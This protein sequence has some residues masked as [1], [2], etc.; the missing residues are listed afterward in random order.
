[1]I[2]S[3][4]LCLASLFLIAGIV[5]AQTETPAK[6]WTSSVGAG[7]AITSGNT[8]TQNYNVSFSTRYDPKRKFVFKSEAL[9]LRGVSNGETQVDRA[10]ASA[11]GEYTYSDRTFAFV[12]VSYLRD[13]FKAI[14]SLVAPVAGGGYRFLRSDVR[15]LTADIAA[16]AQLQDDTV[17]GRTSS[18]SV[19]MGEDFDW[20]LSPTS[21]LTQKFTALWKAEDFDDALYHFDAGLATSVMTRLELKVAYTYDYKNKPPS[22]TVKKGDS[23]LVAALVFKF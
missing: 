12:E 2:R 23:A 10:A 13:P 7:L 5:Q 1:M 15:N 3:R 18:G 9:W 8:D 4:S 20:A 6:P 16:G 17:L 11:R 14:N 21:K 19:K 22:P